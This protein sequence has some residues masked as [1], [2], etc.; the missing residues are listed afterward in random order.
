MK[1]VIYQRESKN[2][3]LPLSVSFTAK[4]ALAFALTLEKYYFSGII[5]KLT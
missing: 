5:L 4:F 1:R 2:E 3:R